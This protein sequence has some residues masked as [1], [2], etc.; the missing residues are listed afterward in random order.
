MEWPLVIQ[1]PCKYP[2]KHQLTKTDTPADLRAWSLKIETTRENITQTDKRQKK[3]KKEIL[4]YIFIS[5][6]VIFDKL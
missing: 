5:S 2:N 3:K 4:I 6:N 1:V